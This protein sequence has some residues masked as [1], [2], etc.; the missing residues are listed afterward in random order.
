MLTGKRIEIWVNSSN[1]VS[2]LMTF[3]VRK[4]GIPADQQR[5][6]YDGKS[7]ANGEIL[8]SSRVGTH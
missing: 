2:D 1:T 4:E 7:L 8:N 3:I 5:L 6:I